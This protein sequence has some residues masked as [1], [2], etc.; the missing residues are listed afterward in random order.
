MKELKQML[1]VKFFKPYKCPVCVALSSNGYMNKLYQI[2]PPFGWFQVDI[3]SD[4]SQLT[5]RLTSRN[6]QVSLLH[7]CISELQYKQR[8]PLE[9]EI[10]FMRFAN[11][12]QNSFRACKSHL[13]T[14]SFW[15]HT[16]RELAWLREKF[17]LTSR[18]CYSSM[19]IHF[20]LVFFPL[21]RIADF[22]NNCFIFW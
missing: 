3:S 15:H 12:H 11:G 14:I 2:L 22:L 9:T 1:Q 13:I 7:R 10:T 21:H 20:L 17:F 5:E 8:K 18:K 16:V 19:F 6:I 4:N